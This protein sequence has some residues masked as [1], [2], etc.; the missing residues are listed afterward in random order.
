MDLTKLGSRGINLKGKTSG[1]IKTTCPRC[2]VDRKKKGDPS[3]SV[4]ID[5]GVWNCHHCGWSGSVN[6]YLR[7][8]TRPALTSDSIYNHFRKRHIKDD[9]VK[10]FNVG[11]AVEWMPQDQK[12]HKVICFNYYMDDELIN[13]KFKTKDKKF[14]MVKGAMKIPYNLDSIK[15]K[16]YVII[17]E[18]EEECMVWHQVGYSSVVSCPNGASTTN[19]NLDWLDR[20][21]ELFKDKQVYLATDSDE[22]GRKLQQDLARRFSSQDVRLISLPLKDANDVL[23]EHGEAVLKELFDSAKPMP[24]K[25]ISKASDYFE[26]IEAYKKDGYPVGAKVNLF[27]TDSLIS[28]SRGELVVITGVPGMGK[29][30]WLDY[31]YLRLAFYQ[32][33]KFG[34]FSPENVPQLKITRMTEQVMGKPIADQ[35]D[36]Q[37]DYALN[38]I[39]SH[40]FFFNIEQMDDYNIDSILDT[41]QM[42]VKRHGIDCLCLDPFNYLEQKGDESSHEKIGLLLRKLKKFATTNDVNVTLVAHPRKMEKTGNQYQV[43]RMYDISGSHHFFNVPDV[44]MAI[45]RDFETGEVSLYVQ[46]VKYHFRGQIGSTEYRFDIPS[47]RYTENESFDVLHKPSQQWKL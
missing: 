14:K 39:D 45:H 3:L 41:A 19:N 28:W 32:G 38:F 43:P 33:W 23:I 42:M 7:P 15:E 13:I 4:N 8:K 17:C 9:V 46:K 18:G 24:V 26:V 27:R 20:V 1:Q 25:E 22:P 10:S 21:Y 16:D 36:M 47:G 12:E 29:T 37:T 35:N 44:G 40:F 11:Q 34:V 6:E 5:E 31:M 2:S 30:T